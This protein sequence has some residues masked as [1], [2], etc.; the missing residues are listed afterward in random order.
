[1][2]TTEESQTGPSLDILDELAPSNVPLKSVDRHISHGLPRLKTPLWKKDNGHPGVSSP[3]TY[4]CPRRSKRSQSGS[5]RKT[6]P[7]IRGSAT[8]SYGTGDEDVSPTSSAPGSPLVESPQ[9][10]APRQT[11][12]SKGKTGDKGLL[13]VTEEV[14]MP[15]AEVQSSVKQ[16][17]LLIARAPRI[18]MVSESILDG[19]KR[20]S[21]GSDC[22]D[23]GRDRS[24][25]GC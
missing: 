12:L 1:M 11:P 19:V 13:P 25:L 22:K 3:E 7:H 9:C 16:S 2:V 6:N 5:G 4:P 18:T 20:F 8:T 15:A 10:V 23:G 21:K 24:G 17:G 14:S